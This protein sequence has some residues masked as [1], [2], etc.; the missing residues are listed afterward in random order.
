MEK[1]LKDVRNRFVSV[2]KTK[3]HYEVVTDLIVFKTPR[4]E[5]R[6]RRE[7]LT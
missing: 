2:E 5:G 7:K 1:L 4:K 6:E 3:E